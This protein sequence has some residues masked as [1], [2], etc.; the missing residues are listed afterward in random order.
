MDKILFGKEVQR[1]D[2]E[3]GEVVVRCGDGS[4]YRADHVIVTVS[5]GV[6]KK[7]GAEMFNPPL[8][9]NKTDGIRVRRQT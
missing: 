6:L 7:H 4:S 3:D 8:P 2:R 9:Q 5:L 1:V